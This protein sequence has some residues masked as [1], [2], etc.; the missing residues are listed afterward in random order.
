MSVEIP[1]VYDPHQVED[2]LYKFW[3][4][5]KYFHAVRKNGGEPYVIMIPPP[6]ITGIL[7]M[8]HALNNAIQDIL[9]R[10]KRM[11]GHNT[12]WMPGTDH[13]GIA[14]Q[15]VVERKLMSE[16]LTKRE[17][18][19]DLFL[20]EVWKWREKY[21]NTIVSQLKLL[22]SSLD[23][24]RMR[25][26]MDDGLSKAVQQVFLSLYRDGL[27]YRGN[28]IINWCP[29]CQTALSDEEAEHMEL[30]GNLFYVRYHIEESSDYLVVATTRP[31]T[32]LGDVAIAVNQK[33]ERYKKWIGKNVVVPITNRKIPIIAD[34]M[35]DPEF[36]TGALKVTPAHD[37]VDFQIAQNHDLKPLNVM[38]D[39]GTMNE[40]AGEIYQG[41]DRF[42]CREAI[43]IDLRDRKLLEKVEAHP[44]SV[45]HCYRCRT[46]V[47][48]R[49][50]KQWFVKMKPLAAPAIEAVKNGEIN[51]YPKRWT[52]VYLDWMENIRDWCISRQIWWG[53]RIP[54]WYCE[55]CEF[56][57]D[58]VEDPKVC[59]KCQWPKLIQDEDVLDTWFSSWLWPFST[60][61]W[62]DKNK[63]LDFYYPSNT[64]TTAQEIIFFWVARMIMGG[65]RF[66]GKKPF[67][68]VYIHGT[69][70][71]DSGTKMSKS[72][73]N[74]IDPQDIIKDFGADALR[75]S[76]IVI[77]AQGQD[78]YLSPSKFEI[79]RNFANKLWN[80]SRFLMMNLQDYDGSKVKDIESRYS[81]DDTYIVGK[82]NILK[83][84][85]EQYFGS[86]RFN[87]AAREIY[88]FFWHHYCDR[89]I[90]VAKPSLL[91]NDEEEK[92]KTQH[93]LLHVLINTMKLL[94]PIMPFI[95]EEIWQSLRK[96]NLNLK[97][98]EEESIMIAAWPKYEEKKDSQKDID[99]AESKFDVIKTAR[100]L[101]LEYDLANSKEVSFVLKPSN[102][103]ELS[104]LNQER[105]SILRLLRASD[106][107][108]DKDFVPSGPTPSGVSQAGLVYMPLDGLIDID[109]EKKRL[110][111]KL[112]Q[113]QS[114]LD[115]VDKKLSNKGFLA[116]APVDVVA[117]EKEKQAEFQ[118]KL[119]KLKNNLSFLSKN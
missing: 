111:S 90:E 50:S 74:I 31:E 44:H 56:V 93:V 9:I 70:R 19:R 52:K 106:L 104:L 13:A 87:D 54:I 110:N 38:N 61:G 72:L 3:T 53:H 6:N 67:S 102:D 116:K 69:V 77:T 71:D 49:L 43:V 92:Q 78:V 45:G 97:E 91:G 95:T 5:K 2:K 24:D 18:G 114:D 27:I 81:L 11:D 21:G 105:D 68:D 40:E 37:P 51:F 48:P 57:V 86:Y 101:R 16:G 118:E 115:R 66:M 34:H 103:K 25:F 107:T 42:E 76:L 59:P 20:E 88:D 75:F 80:A 12:L 36:G 100:N 119:E 82:L 98:L 23:W 85:V 79:G 1:K 83:K 35:V 47:E 63:D 7:H 99:L 33:D 22:G 26:T 29:R 64:L 84:D 117:K 108:V 14:T 17:L 113:V 73:G 32:L 4:R 15:N 89:Y 96:M 94:H 10:W 39:D 112:E 60:L 28:Y 65:Y 8:G 41:M 58:S 109:V 46:V 62:P 55:D 30:E